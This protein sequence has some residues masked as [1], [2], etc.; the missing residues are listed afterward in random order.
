MGVTTMLKGWC[1]Q[2]VKE[3]GG[4]MLQLSWS[5]RPRILGCALTLGGM[6][7]APAESWAEERC[8]TKP[9]VCARMKAL[10]AAQPGRVSASPSGQARHPGATATV[11]ALVLEDT[12]CRTK[13]ISCARQPREWHSVRV[14]VPA[15]VASYPM[16]ERCSSKPGVC[17]RWKSRGSESSPVYWVNAAPAL[18][19]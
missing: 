4:P 3:R 10:R 13:P 11:C 5:W 18:A 12:R 14:T 2:T 9:A 7:L 6:A 8:T 15:R 1:G 19:C 16:T 17:T